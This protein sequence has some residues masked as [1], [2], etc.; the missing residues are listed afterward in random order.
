MINSLAQ[1]LNINRTK[2]YK[3]SWDRRRKEQLDQSALVEMEVGEADQDLSW[4][5]GKQAQKILGRI[6]KF[7]LRT[8]WIVLAQIALTVVFT[9]INFSL[10]YIFIF[11]IIKNCF[12]KNHIKI[13][14]FIINN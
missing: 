13:H 11:L 4:L 5:I 8:N 7:L 10:Q 9:I 12:A 14:H 6:Y 1:T 2:V 3:W